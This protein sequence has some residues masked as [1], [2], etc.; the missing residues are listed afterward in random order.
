MDS[1]ERKRRKYLQQMLKKTKDNMEEE[2][3]FMYK[4]THDRHMKEIRDK[5]KVSPNGGSKPFKSSDER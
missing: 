2:K 5:N 1:I 4:Q 3:S